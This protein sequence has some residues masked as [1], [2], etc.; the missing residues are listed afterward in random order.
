VDDRSPDLRT[1]AGQ[2]VDRVK[3]TRAARTVAWYGARRGALL[4]GGIAYSAVFSLAA[5]LTIGFSVFFATLGGN[6]G[7]RR[8]VFDQIDTWLP[9]L[10]ATG[11]G[12]GGVL[13]PDSLVLPS[14]INVYSIGASV[15]LLFTATRFMRALRVGVRAMFDVPAGEESLVLSKVWELLGFAILG[16][17][18]L[19]SAAAS[20]V[21]QAVSR[22]VE[23]LLGTS[24]VV[25]VL[26]ALGTAA[27]GV[28]LDAVL[29]LLVVRVVAHVRPRRTRDLVLG[30]LAAGVVASGLRWL[31]TSFVAATATRN[32]LLASFAVL[33][34]VL[35]LVNFVARVLLLAC[36]WMY[37]P[38]RPDEVAHAE[39][40]VE[41]RRH[42]AEVDRIVAQGQGSGLPWSPIV[43]G[44]RRARLTVPPT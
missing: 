22:Q 17:M 26:V 3:D 38:P 35:V 14:A 44:I 6:A 16:G 1:R 42:A 2:V 8:A 33:A 36:A 12:T 15:V 10:L 28:V 19:T 20:I 9:G 34:T 21:S 25:V 7:L 43:R 4:C 23:A 5:A 29:V 11:D 30:C 13:E 40:E 31:G 27:V 24:A 37:D 32:A 41:A 18:V 39:A